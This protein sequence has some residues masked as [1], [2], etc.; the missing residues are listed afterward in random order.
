MNSDKLLAN[1]ESKNK[2]SQFKSQ[3][4]KDSMEFYK[5]IAEN[6]NDM[7]AVINENY[8]YEYIN[9]K[10]SYKI[11][12][13]KKEALIGK[14]PLE[15]IHPK[16]LKQ[17]LTLLKKG[18]ETGEAT[19]EFR[20]KHQNG[21]WVWLESR[22]KTFYDSDGVKKGIIISRNISE[23]V[24]IQQQLGE[25][26]KELTLINKLTNIIEQR[27]LD[28]D[29]LLKKAVGF[30]P[31]AFQFPESTC[32]IITYKEK[33]VKTEYFKETKWSIRSHLYIEGNKEGTVRVY[34]TKKV[35]NSG[36]DPFLEEERNLI[37]HF[38]NTLS[39]LI[40]RIEARRK[41]EELLKKYDTLFNSM[42][43]AFAYHKVLYDQNNKPID[44]I[45]LEVNA[46]FEKMTGLKKEDI[47]G[48]K[49][50][51][52][53]PGIKSDPANWIKIYGEVAKT[54]KQIEFEQYAMLLKKWFYITAY[55][56]KKNYFACVF[57]DISERKAIETKLK[58]SEKKHKKFA[59][60]MQIILDALPSLVFYKDRENRFIRINK[61]LADAHGMN[62]EDLEGKS[63][64]ELY[65]EEEAQNYW[66]DDLEVIESGEAKLNIE[67]KIKIM[68]G[69]RW[70]S[71]SKIPY[72]NEEGD[73]EGIIG[74]SYDITE[75]KRVEELK[76]KYNL[77]L[78]KKVEHRTKQLEEEIQQKNILLE[79]ILQISEFK[80]N[81]MSQMSHELRTPLNSIIGFTELLLE[82]SFGPLLS[83]QEEYL[84]D[85]QTSANHLLYLINSIMDISKIET[86]KSNFKINS[87]LLKPTIEDV[88]SEFKPLLNQKKIKINI[89]DI[90][91]DFEIFTDII[92]FKSVLQNLLSIAIECYKKGKIRILLVEEPN[93]WKFKIKGQK[94]D[95]AKKEIEKRFHKFLEVENPY[96]ANFDGIGLTLP[97]TRKLVSLLGGELRLKRKGTETLTFIFTIP[98]RSRELSRTRIQNFLKYL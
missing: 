42:S 50:T 72:I 95:I 79:K 20:Y 44:Y 32:G 80:S 38:T 33:R 76:D 27:G 12:G 98:K 9:E 45:F 66:E 25:R 77:E 4:N 94:V 46:N 28:I 91:K 65:P 6:A 71:T 40:E 10:A 29:Q 59:K 88:I 7:I 5:L 11:M 2:K 43:A 63:C 39:T 97:L 57:T 83:T 53:L 82:E 87:F 52:I 41:L 64:F 13:Y 96:I 19:M 84:K 18:F 54:G 15:F 24:E 17:V 3:M 78:E 61:A 73:I 47:I 21:H 56:P 22:G 67:E 48:K 68:D 70:L 37:A 69:E 51:T 74:I 26:V 89:K 49:I 1:N 34:S 16:D 31:A 62:K 85:I 75:L 90:K 81:F 30:L 35:H 60:E 92:K 36:E 8:K 14:S 86:G 58:D 93:A 23:R 55:S